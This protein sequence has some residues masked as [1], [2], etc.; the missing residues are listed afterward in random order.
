MT[1][2][3]MDRPLRNGLCRVGGFALIAMLAV[4]TIQII[5]LVIWPPP[6]TVD[7]LFELFNRNWFLGLLSMDLLYILNNTLL[8]LVYLGLFAALYDDSPAASLIGLLFGVTAIAA[9]YGSNTS[10]EMLSLSRQYSGATTEAQ[11]II[12]LA[13]GQAMLETYGGTG[14]DAYYVLSAITL[15]IF[16][17]VMHRGVVFSRAATLWALASGILMIIPSTAGT[18]GLVFSLLSLAPW[19]V[20]CVLGARTLLSLSKT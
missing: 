17:W 8:I 14:F 12:P 9:Y 1:T 2:K 16:A 6:D 10:F 4:T 15:L 20:F 18:V 7:G 13:A 11:R 19:I 5:V 3:E